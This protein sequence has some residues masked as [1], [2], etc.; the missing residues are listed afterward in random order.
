M[1]DLGKKEDLEIIEDFEKWENLIII[2]KNWKKNKGQKFKS[3]TSKL[4]PYF[5]DKSESFLD[6][7]KKFRFDDIL[8]ISAAQ[9]P[10]TEAS[11][12][13]KINDIHD[14]KSF[15]NFKG[16]LTVNDSIRINMTALDLNQTVSFSDKYK[17]TYAKKKSFLDLV[18]RPVNATKT[19]QRPL[20]MENYMNTSINTTAN[21]FY[22]RKSDP[23]SF[24]ICIY[25]ITTASEG[26]DLFSNAAETYFNVKIDQLIEQIL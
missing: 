24:I 4:N 21:E 5:D 15:M 26:V 6:N 19:F 3:K 22:P 17:S 25:T 1:E 10:S 9:Y 7:D 20:K 2:K 18:G 13:N 12:P 16:N 8:K 11:N 14:S 23:V